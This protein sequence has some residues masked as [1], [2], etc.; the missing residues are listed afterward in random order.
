MEK[1]RVEGKHTIE[2]P[3]WFIF[4][5]SNGIYSMDGGYYLANELSDYKTI[6]DH[7]L[8]FGKDKVFLDIGAQMGLSTLPIAAEGY[9]VIAIEPVKRNLTLLKNNL[10]VNNFDKVTVFP[11]AAYSSEAE[12]T[13]YVPAEEDCASI[14]KNAANVI[15]REAVPEI[16]RA[17][18]IDDM[19][20][21][22]QDIAFIKID[23]QGAELEV[24][25][26]MKGML[27]EKIE[28]SIYIEW[29]PNY[30]RAYGYEPKELHDLLVACGYERKDNRDVKE[31]FGDVIYT[32]SWQFYK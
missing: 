22:S 30:M 13:M 11:Y 10:E 27:C 2:V 21:N 15:D 18:R 26:G 19:I 25:K 31:F 8:K 32:N 14:S 12:I 17:A 1:I 23:V 7:M 5:R 9:S 29:D 28:R 3:E 4:N 24:I 16:V 20:E 6:K